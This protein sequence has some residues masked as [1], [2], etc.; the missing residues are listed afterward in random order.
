MI[1]IFF[2][3]ERKANKEQNKIGITEKRRIKLKI[4]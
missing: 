3:K 4:K 2:L 1:K